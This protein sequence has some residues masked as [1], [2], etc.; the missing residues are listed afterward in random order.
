[1]EIEAY[2]K[3]LAQDARLFLLLKLQD[4]KTEGWIPIHAP[5]TLLSADFPF[6]MLLLAIL[7][8]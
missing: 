3:S 7:L 6:K 2:L 8:K 1:L 5:C 4:G